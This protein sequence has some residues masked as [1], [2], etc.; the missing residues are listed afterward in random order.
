MAFRKSSDFS[1]KDSSG[2]ISTNLTHVGLITQRKFKNNGLDGS[3]YFT[4]LETM[5]N[6]N[7]RTLVVAAT[8]RGNLAS[9]LFGEFSQIG[10]NFGEY[11]DSMDSPTS[12]NVNA[13][14]DDS[15]AMD[16]KFAMMEQTIEA[17]EKFVNDK[18]LNIAQLM[19]K[20]EIF[21]PGE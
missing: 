6:N 16:E 7:S 15:T 21:T 5:K 20:L 2:V 12:M 4:S 1:Y 10:Y 14:M 8:P 11:E 9:V 3:V 18:N 13:L 17:L 19:N